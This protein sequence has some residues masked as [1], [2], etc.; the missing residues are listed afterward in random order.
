KNL[1]PEKF[2]LLKQD[3]LVKAIVSSSVS[4]TFDELRKKVLSTAGYLQKQNISDGDRV[5][6]I[7]QNDVDFVINILALWQISAV[8]VPL[9]NRLT[10]TEIGEQLL[11]ANCSSLL[12]Q[13]EFYE[14]VK[15]SSKK[16]I[17]Y[18][19]FADYNNS[20]S[21][22]DKLDVND[23]AVIIFTSGS[24]NKSKGIILSFNSLYNSTLGSNQLLRYTRSDRWMASLPFYHIGGFSIIT[25]SLLFGIPLIIPDSFSTEVLA[26]SL[27][28]WQPTFIS[29]VAAQLKKLVDEN[30]SPNHELKNCLIGGG[31]SDIEII[32]KAYDLGWP[33]N[34]VYGST[35][36]SSFVTALLKDEIL[37]KANS[38]GRAVPT[39]KILITDNEENELKPFEIGEIVVQSN[40]L[41][42][43]Y[44]NE[45][46]TKGVIKNGIYHTG[47]IGFLDEDGFLFI[48]G[49]KNFLISTGGENVNPIEVE[50]ALL[51]H[52]FIEEAAVFPLKDNEWGE[53]I[54]AAIVIKSKSVHLSYDE[55]KIFLQE[56]IS[57]FKIPKKVFFEDQLPKTELGK[58]EKDKL[59]SRYKLT[60]L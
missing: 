15:S 46:E 43:G 24:T 38:V 45:D 16:N 49:R 37:F 41:M 25:R 57:S 23:A 27:S 11:S 22:R 39:N 50:K 13:N 19:F 10:E 31:F 8:P 29:L 28:K 44:V 5:G 47:D 4:Y 32:K 60:S 56:R 55:L 59:I 7:G 58:V 12:V 3:L 18:P 54:A 42:S 17:N 35:E 51:K 14:K 36:T 40:A 2:I 26:E 48:E 1:S 6:I 34:I 30:I 53:I 20:F 9:N 33:V 21:G 52:P